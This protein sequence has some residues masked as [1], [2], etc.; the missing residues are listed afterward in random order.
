MQE[1]SERKRGKKRETR[2]IE[3]LCGYRKRERDRT[4]MRAAEKSEVFVRVLR[5]THKKTATER[6]KKCVSKVQG[7]DTQR[8]QNK[9]RKKQG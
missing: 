1:V 3:S 7:K 4:S 2:E 6:E 9:G 8:T 5:L